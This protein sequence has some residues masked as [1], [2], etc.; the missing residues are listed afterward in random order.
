MY[1][2]FFTSSFRISTCYEKHFEFFD[3]LVYHTSKQDEG[4]EECR[5]QG[6]LPRRSSS[7]NFIICI[8]ASLYLS[9]SLF[10]SLSLS[11]YMYTYICMYIYMYIN[12]IYMYHC[13]FFILHLSQFIPLIQSLT[14]PFSL[15][16]IIPLI[17][18]FSFHRA[19]VHQTAFRSY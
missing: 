3:S 1:F 10:F 14:L 13:F 16:Y 11:I 19:R 12:S 5:V 9:A 17:S 7:L 8:L 4:R 18:S 2:C 6:P 15:S